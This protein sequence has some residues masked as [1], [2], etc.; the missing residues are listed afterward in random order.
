M[1]CPSV[2]IFSSVK[3]PEDK[4]FGP[5]E[6]ITHE[7]VPDAQLPDFAR[8]EFTEARTAAREAE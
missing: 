3:G 1:P 8:V 7:M 2:P 6:L 4:Y 5:G